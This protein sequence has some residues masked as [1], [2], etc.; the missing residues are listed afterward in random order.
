VLSLLLELQR[1]LRLGMVFITHDL[2]VAARVCH[3]ILVMHEGRVEESGTPDEIFER[4][5]AEYTRRLI[6][7]I[8]GRS[9]IPLSG[10][11]S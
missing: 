3:R 1:R 4:P 7:A 2:R 8:P 11:H 6:D 9:W 10:V 5:R